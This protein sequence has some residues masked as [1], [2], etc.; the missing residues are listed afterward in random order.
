MAAQKSS[1]VGT[2][3]TF[4]SVD[5][6]IL[7]FD[8]EASGGFIDVT[9]LSS[10]TVEKIAK[11]LKDAGQL[12]VRAIFQNAVNYYAL[13]NTKATLVLDYTNGLDDATTPDGGQESCDAIMTDYRVSGEGD[14]FMTVEMT[15]AR[16][17]AVTP[18]IVS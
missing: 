14:E 18:T 17:G 12:T 6:E 7:G 1:A 11:A 4:N 8:V 16:T 9:D 15:F 10:T 3:I 13:L 5:H 2:K